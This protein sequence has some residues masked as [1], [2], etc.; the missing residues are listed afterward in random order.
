MQCVPADRQYADSE[1][2]VTSTV[3]GWE[4]LLLYACL[5]TVFICTVLLLAPDAAWG[6]LLLITSCCTLY[7]PGFRMGQ[8]VDL[9]CNDAAKWLAGCPCPL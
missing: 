9:L 2:A 6:V 5:D 7:L 8:A 1:G 4:R 3:M